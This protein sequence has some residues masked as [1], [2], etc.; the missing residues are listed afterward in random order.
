MLPCI[1][2]YAADTAPQKG[3]SPRSKSESVNPPKAAD[4]VKPGTMDRMPQGVAPGTAD[5]PPKPAAPGT[6]DKNVI[7]PDV[8][9]Q[10]GQKP[11]PR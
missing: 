3:D 7:N 9:I 11:V 6:L 4:P 1:N 2:A 8:E 5:A 10:K